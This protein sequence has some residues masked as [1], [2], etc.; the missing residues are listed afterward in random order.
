MGVIH[1]LKYLQLLWAPN[2]TPSCV[3]YQ[4]EEWGA[5]GSSPVP[6]Y[7]RWLC[8]CVASCEGC[9]STATCR[10]AFVLPGCRLSHYLICLL[11]VQLLCRGFG[12]MPFSPFALQSQ[13]PGCNREQQKHYHSGLSCSC[14]YVQLLQQ[15]CMLQFGTV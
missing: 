12:T 6:T 14:L 9:T 13:P 10:C 1:C 4:R 11:S 2:F 8:P 3:V 15:Y 7:W 5:C